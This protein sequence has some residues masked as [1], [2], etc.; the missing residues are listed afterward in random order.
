MT[1]IPINDREKKITIKQKFTIRELAGSFGDWGTL[2]PFVI[3]Y[4]SIVGLNPAGIFICLGLTNIILG[5]K[6]NLPLPVQPQKTIGTISLSQGWNQ[7][8]VIST[9]FGTGVFWFI[10]G[11]SK[12]LNKI[13]DKVP[14]ILVRGIQLGLGLI[15]GW[16]AL[17][18]MYDNLIL[19]II[20][21]AIIIGLL[22]YEKI[23]S[24]IL[25]VF[26]G[27]TIM[28]FAGE[29]NLDN[30]NLQLPHISFYIPNLYDLLYGMLI[31]GIGQLILTLANVMIAT[32]VLARDLFP[33]RAR[34]IDA[35]TLSFNMGY[36]N[37]LSP[38]IGGI[39][40]CH[41]SGGLAAQYA[42]GARTGGS[43]ILEGLIEIVLGVFFSN[44]LLN[45][46]TAFPVSIFGAM[47]LYTAFL[48]AKVSFK[49]FKMKEFILIVIPTALL[50]FF[51]NLPIGFGI[52]LLI[53]AI[54]KLVDK[55]SNK[56]IAL[57]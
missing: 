10:L 50:S 16:E 47:L 45:I 29:I 57:N 19:A 48:L 13:V 3:G 11:I 33:D 54:L 55:K 2:I 41:G 4:I 39:P 53:Y 22:K 28:I 7:S 44:L 21:L 6:F 40:L 37:L 49:Q 20:S 42:F 15:L 17:T 36:I 46:F 14:L 34:K 1:S 9:G 27:I 25:L 38:F 8:L 24:S 23:P 30:L 18:L 5:I 56:R 26:L 31:A 52:G 35:N 43:M 12:K 51:I 32:I